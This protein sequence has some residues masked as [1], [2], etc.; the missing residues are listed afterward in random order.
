MRKFWHGGRS[1]SRTSYEAMGFLS[2]SAPIRRND[3]YA[4]RRAAAWGAAAMSDEGER[5]SR[6]DRRRPMRGGFRLPF[7]L[8]PGRLKSHIN[9]VYVCHS[10]QAQAKQLG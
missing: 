6:R 9:R 5:G 4:R 10:R 2:F 3:D 7:P 1:A 8:A